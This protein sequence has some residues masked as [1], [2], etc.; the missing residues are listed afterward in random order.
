MDSV[1]RRKIGFI[2]WERFGYG[3]V[4]RVVSGLIKHFSCGNDV[5]VLC[6]KDSTFF[7][8]VY[9]IPTDRVNFSFM[10]MS[11]LQKVRREA[12]NRLFD[13][14]FFSPDFWVKNCV[15][16][17][18]ASSYLKKIVDWINKGGF[19]I[20]V[21]STGFED[22]IQLAAIKPMLNPGIKTVAWSHAGFTDYFRNPLSSESICRLWGALYKSF[23][24]IVVLSDADVCECRK[25]LNLEATR[26]Y[27][28]N[29]F[30]PNLRTDLSHRRFLYLGA[31]SETKGSDILIEAFIEF[32]RHN[33]DWSLSLY[34][35]GAISR[36][37][38][39]R[40][41]EHGLQS[42]VF[43]HPYTLDT[44]DVYTKH[45]VFILPSRYEG[46]GIVQI[47]AASCGLPVISSDVAISREL[48]ARYRNGKLFER[49]NA[50]ALARQMLDI[51]NE[52]LHIYSDRSFEAAK[53]FT[54]E[55]IFSD[56]DQ[57]IGKLH[58]L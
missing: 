25:M 17:K 49:G 43:L 29:S 38:E 2:A 5:E 57:L 58:H 53:D 56:W 35:E 32:S 48:N 23:D 7:Q 24:S 30:K 34:G 13:H 14:G 16:L 37:I 4:S 50:H 15:R 12:V 18:Y 19:D 3:G 11:L 31:L 6:L 20:V 33:A 28:P 54:P 8:N 1:A 40:I 45:D 39:R 46:F 21:F 51:V 26:I 42:R 36:W 9:E 52:D 55:R 41:A 44:R 22:C 27:N 10:E 47:E